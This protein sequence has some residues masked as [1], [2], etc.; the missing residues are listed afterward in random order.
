VAIYTESVM[1]EALD[2]GFMGS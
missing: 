2:I 1:I